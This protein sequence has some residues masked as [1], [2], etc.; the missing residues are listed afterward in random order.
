[1]LRLSFGLTVWFI[2]QVFMLRYNFL[3]LLQSYIN[4]EDI[5]YFPPFEFRARLQ[6]SFATIGCMIMLSCSVV[7]G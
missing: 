7:G 2:D 1:M 4:G 3:I 6:F 5:I